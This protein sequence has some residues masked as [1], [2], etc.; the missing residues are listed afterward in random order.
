M[1]FGVRVHVQFGGKLG[2]AEVYDLCHSLAKNGR[3]L[4]G[5]G[6]PLPHQ[7][8]RAAAKTWENRHPVGTK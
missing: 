6:G 5:F 2:R 4:V 8:L 1:L 3:R 7:K